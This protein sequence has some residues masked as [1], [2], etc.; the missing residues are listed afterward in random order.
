MMFGKPFIVKDREDK[1]YLKV[2]RWTAVCAAIIGV[3]L[4]PIYAQEKSIYVAH[5][6]FIATI[7]P[8]MIVVILLSVFWKRFTPTAAFMTLVCGSLLV[9]I[10]AFYPQIITPFSHGIE[11]SGGYKF[12]RAFFGII[13]ALGIG[14]IVTYFTKPKSDEELKGLTID[15][16]EDA[17]RYYKGGREPNDEEFGEKVRLSGRIKEI[18]GIEISSRAL[19]LLKGKI[20]DIVYV[21]DYRWYFGGLRSIHATISSVH[22]D[23][24]DLVYLCKENFNDGHFRFDKDLVVEKVI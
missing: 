3:L 21:S 16:F 20:G 18:E 1:Y 22:N 14:V 8:A 7:T 17:K 24:D 4:V 23:A 11:P 9:G 5:G 2:A 13:F 10:S 15:S 12:M 19:K 6:K